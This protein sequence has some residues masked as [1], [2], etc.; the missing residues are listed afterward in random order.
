MLA[1][2][3]IRRMRGGAQSQL[4]LGADGKLWVV[5]FQNNPQHLRVLANELIATRLAQTA[6][7]TVPSSDVVEVTEWLIAN[8][9]DMH[10]EMPRGQREKYRAGLQFGSQ[11]VGGL[12]PGQVVDYL[13]EQQ[14][15]EVRNLQEFAGMLALDKWTGNC[16]GRQAV[17]D[18][19]PRERKYRATFIDQGY[20]F[21]AG[22]WT[23]PDTPLRGV[24][25]RN[26]VYAGVT[27]WM[28]FEPWLSRMETMEAETL[29]AIAEI[30]PPEWYGGDTAVIERLTE[31][32]LVRRGRLR[33]LIGSFRDSNREPFPMWEKKLSVCVPRQFAEDAVGKFVM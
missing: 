19:K 14:L 2:Q 1:V 12:M 25:A 27:G 33:E 28:S 9:A 4:M 30:V 16:N 7:L 6:G 8:T 13:P 20:C 18:R 15:D 26:Q 29:W 21:N 22:E 31:Q 24:Y 5:K 10:V 32:M 11:F 17:F 3:A 23:F